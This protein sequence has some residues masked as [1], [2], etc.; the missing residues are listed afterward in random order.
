MGLFGAPGKAVSV[1]LYFVASDAVAV[2]FHLVRTQCLVT[3]VI[4]GV[5]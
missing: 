4:E 3:P 1:T 5:I 2:A